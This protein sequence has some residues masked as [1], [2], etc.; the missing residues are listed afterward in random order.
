MHNA[1]LAMRLRAEV[2][3]TVAQADELAASRRR[4]LAAQESQR[5]LLR[6][7]IGTDVLPHLAGLRPVLAQQATD[8][9]LAA[10]AVMISRALEALRDLA[11]GVFPPILA[12]RGLGAAL[13]RYAGRPDG[14][15]RLTVAA[16]LR[17]ARFASHVEAV[18]YFCVVETV[19]EFAGSARV[20]LDLDDGCLLLAVS[21]VDRGSRPTSSDGVVDRVLAC[22]GTVTTSGPTSTESG[23]RIRMPAPAHAP[24]SAHTAASWSGPN[25]AFDT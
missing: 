17:T 5:Q 18:L 8:G 4:L 15:V 21:A 1:Q 11:R 23:L 22:G 12:H 24:A 10:A 3:R 9:S 13:G 16:P 19:R 25:A 20:E 2:A 7:A 14:R 6:R